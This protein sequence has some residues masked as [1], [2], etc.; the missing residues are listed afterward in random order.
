MSQGNVRARRLLDNRVETHDETDTV[1]FHTV[2][3]DR[4]RG[5]WCVLAGYS[6]E[7]LYCFFE[8]SSFYMEVK[9]L[10]V[11]QNTHNPMPEG[12]LYSFHLTLLSRESIC[13]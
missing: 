2:S 4:L 5:N 6:L 12:F 3:G 1:D 9:L 7:A 8:A 11:W 13:L 10:F